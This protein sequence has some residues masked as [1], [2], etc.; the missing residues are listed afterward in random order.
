MLGFLIIV[1]GYTK[2]VITSHEI[3]ISNHSFNGHCGTII[4]KFW[5]KLELK[6][7][8]SSVFY[9]SLIPKMS[10]RQNLKTPFFKN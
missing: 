7:M 9:I 8:V 1:G 3:I 10:L 4:L 5:C 2:K 6:P